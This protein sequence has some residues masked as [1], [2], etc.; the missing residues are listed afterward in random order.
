MDL[1]NFP[2]ALAGRLRDAGVVAVLV[3]DRA[4][5]AVPLAETLFRA[6]I[7]AIELTLRT[8]VACQA[9]EAI[10]QHLP[11]MIVGAGT[12]TSPTMV[13][14]VVDVDAAFAVAPGMNATVVRAAGDHGLPFGPGICTPSD[15]E[16]AVELGCRLLKFFPAQPIGG[17]DYLRAIHGP[18]AHLGLRF[19]PLGGIN[20]DNADAYLRDPSVH[21]IGGSWIAPRKLINQQ[22][23]KTIGERAAQAR[24]I[25]DAIAR[26]RENEPS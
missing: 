5:D 4:E 19:V 25:A 7:T 26:E 18:Y 15:I 12:V 21:C 2:A 22:Q 10:R 23:W 11:E 3:I 17:I 8:D 20:A 14:Q 24:Q 16:A 6:G 13:R 9:I 1:G